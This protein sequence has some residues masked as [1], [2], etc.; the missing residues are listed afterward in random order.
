MEIQLTTNTTPT[1]I[2]ATIP[3]SL[4]LRRVLGVTLSCFCLSG[5]AAMLVSGYSLDPDP[6]LE[7]EKAIR[8][9]AAFET[10]CDPAKLEITV[11]A[12]G[13]GGLA[14]YHDDWATTVGAEGCG[15]RLVYVRIGREWVANVQNSA[16]GH[17]PEH[18]A[19]TGAAETL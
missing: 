1:P 11:L 2:S 19:P 13:P 9:R 17:E 4:A 18:R 5:C 3:R 10:R 14:G 6:W 15:Q 16:G 12:V 8:R 7:D